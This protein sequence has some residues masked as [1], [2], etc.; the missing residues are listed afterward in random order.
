MALLMRRVRI[1]NRIN[2]KGHRK[3]VGLKEKN[4]EEKAA[5][6]ASPSL[7]NENF[8]ISRLK[9][10]ICPLPNLRMLPTWKKEDPFFYITTCTNFHEIDIL[11]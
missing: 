9:K 6:P 5:R 4:T 3:D 8:I 7:K 10:K 1:L 2:V 11:E